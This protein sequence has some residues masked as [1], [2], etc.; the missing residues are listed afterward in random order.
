MPAEF[1]GIPAELSGI[2]AEF[3]E[4]PPEFLRIP[5]ELRKIRGA[6]LLFSPHRSAMSVADRRA[7]MLIHRALA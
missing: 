3:L 5:T 2:P 4:T 7:A 1:P 6:S